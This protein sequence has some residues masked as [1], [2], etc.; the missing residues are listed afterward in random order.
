MKDKVFYWQE[1]KSKI[2]SDGSKG[3][4][5]LKGKVISIE[6]AMVGLD[7]GTRL[8]KVNMTKLRKALRGN[9]ELIFCYQKSAN[10]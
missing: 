10:P 3:G 6:G 1:D 8:I 9:P 7:L 4:V 2:R 5:W